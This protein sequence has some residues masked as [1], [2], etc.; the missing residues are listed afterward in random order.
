MSR[1]QIIIGTTNESIRRHAL[2]NQWGLNDLIKNG[3]EIEAAARGAQLL[4]KEETIKVKR[5]KPGKY[6]GKSQRRHNEKP[7]I[8]EN[9]ERCKCCTSRTCKGGKHCPGFKIKCFDC[10]VIGHFK[11]TAICKKKGSSKGTRRV[12]S[13]SDKNTDSASSCT[14]SDP[15]SKEA[16][17]ESSDSLPKVSRTK[18][19]YNKK[20]VKIKGV[21]KVRKIRRV[22]GKPRYEVEIVVK[23]SKIKAFADTG[24]DICVMSKKTAKEC[25]LPLSKTKVKIRPFGSKSMRCRGCY[26]GTVMCG[27][28]VANA[29]IYIVDQDVETLLSGPLSEELGI[30]SFK[31]PP[32]KGNKDAIREVKTTDK[33]KAHYIH[34]S[35]YPSICPYSQVWEG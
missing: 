28:N 26:T 9:V 12:E 15:S 14:E 25:N 32:E 17:Q 16:S 19:K 30:I 27:T 31:P 18:S 22:T 5:V 20:I 7:K 24:A 8:S 33:R 29:C 10:G 34:G 13:D 2:K 1:D 35:K 6:S 4:K 3:R 21:R 23:E 11:G